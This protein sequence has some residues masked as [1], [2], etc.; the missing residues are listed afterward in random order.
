MTQD[1][2]AQIK[3]AI[4]LLHT[5]SSVEEVKEKYREAL[6]N[7]DPLEIAKIEDELVR[8]GMQK[9]EIR[10]LCDVHMAI[11]KEQLEKNAPKISPNEPIN[12]LMEEH[13]IMLQLSDDLRTRNTKIQKVHDTHY[14]EEDIHQV[15]HIA[16]DFADSE[17]HFAREENVLFPLLEKHGITEPP[18]VMWMEHSELKEQ[19]K[20]LHEL[21]SNLEKIGFPAYK[22]QLNEVAQ[23]LGNMLQ[24]HFYKE[25]NILF[26]TALTVVSAEEWLEARQE[27]DEIGYCCFT[28]PALIET[29]KIEKAAKAE[30]KVAGAF[31]FETGFFTKEQLSVLLNTLPFEITF[32]DAEDTVRFFNKPQNMIFLRTKSVIGRK[33]QQCHPAKSLHIVAE[34]VEAFKSGKKNMAEFWLTFNGRYVYIRFFALRDTAGKYLGTIEVVQDITDLQKIQGEKRLL[35]WKQQ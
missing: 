13:R 26:P 19:K 11:F 24:S 9:N 30:A 6:E 5:G 14:V 16:Q 10:K 3:E 28:P 15:E 8:E 29:A 17:K 4:R 32:V 23:L 27:F 25:N 22:Q 18:A 2:K 1:R 20:K 7:A 33:V 35:N 31:Q 21:A 34:I 12:I